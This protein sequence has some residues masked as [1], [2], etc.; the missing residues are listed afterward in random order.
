MFFN[1]ADSGFVNE[2]VSFLFLKSL[3]DYGGSLRIYR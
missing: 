2:K 1:Q 3:Y